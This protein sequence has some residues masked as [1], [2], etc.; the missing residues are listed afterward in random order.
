MPSNTS[1]GPETNGNEKRKNQEG[2]DM[3]NAYGKKTEPGTIRIERVLPGPIE[4]IW[5]YLTDP[6]KRATWFAGGAMEL[7]QGGKATLRFQHK[8]LSTEPTPPEFKDMEHGVT[9]TCT[10]TRCEPPRV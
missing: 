7:R 4:R 10:I 6:E 8:D 2:D 5:A 9:C 1:C 3:T